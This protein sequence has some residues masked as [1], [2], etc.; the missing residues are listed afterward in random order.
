MYCV[1]CGGIRVTKPKHVFDETERMEN[2][3]RE[4]LSDIFNS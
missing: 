3:M 1:C 4:I 2:Q